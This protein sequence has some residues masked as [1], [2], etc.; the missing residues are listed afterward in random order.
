VPAWLT[1]AIS[2]QQA[3][4]NTCH[5]RL[6]LHPQ[7]SRLLRAFPDDISMGILAG[8]QEFYHY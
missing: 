3:T 4:P 5:V 8:G 6:E 2:K 7:N 1:D